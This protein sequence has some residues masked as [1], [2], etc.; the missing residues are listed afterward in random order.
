M[1]VVPQN[2][3]VPVSL[4]LVAIPKTGTIRPPTAFGALPRSADLAAVMGLRAAL[5]LA[6]IA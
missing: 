5:R 2:A 1:V 3:A 4:S 6:P